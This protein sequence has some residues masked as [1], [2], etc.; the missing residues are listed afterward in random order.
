MLDNMTFTLAAWTDLV[1]P[2]VV[3]ALVLGSWINGALKK[4]GDERKKEVGGGDNELEVMASLRREQLRQATRQRGNAASQS[5]LQPNTSQMSMAERIAQARA[6]AQQEQR[7]QRPPPSSGQPQQQAA[8]RQDAL[9]Q[10]QAEIRRRQ[11]AAQGKQ[12]AQQQQQQQVQQQA[13]RRAQQQAQQRARQQQAQAHAKAQAQARHRG[14]LL[15]ETVEA[16]KPTTSTV[17]KRVFKQ[18]PPARQSVPELIPEASGP[19]RIGNLSLAELR[20]AIVLNEVL[21]KPVAL[22]ETQSF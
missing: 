13:Q 14:V 18:A 19:P 16:P 12:R 15:H 22:R 11:Q 1:G 17:R 4:Y 9:A 8:G 2:A 20:K 6:K 21:G 3:V 5:G 10:R 7:S